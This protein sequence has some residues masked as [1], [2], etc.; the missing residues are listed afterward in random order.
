[1][2]ASR[3]L[4]MTTLTS[5]D[6]YVHSRDT[7]PNSSSNCCTSR[8]RRT[9][10]VEYEIWIVCLG[11]IDDDPSPSN[12][13]CRNA[14]LTAGADRHTKS[15]TRLRALRSPARSEST[16]A[17]S[18]SSRWT[19]SSCSTLPDRMRRRLTYRGPPT[20][21]SYAARTRKK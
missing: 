3:R 8:A 10:R 13:D 16:L 1:M 7:T 17:R 4:V 20:A 9:L 15:G 5:P 14:R 18:A 19:S 11:R 6:G 2:R 21:V 12:N